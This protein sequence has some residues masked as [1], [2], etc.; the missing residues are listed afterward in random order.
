EPTTQGKEKHM[1][2]IHD[3]RWLQEELTRLDPQRPPHIDDCVA[4]YT[5]IAELG[6]GA[7]ESILASVRRA[8]PDPKNPPLVVLERIIRRRLHNHRKQNA[9][10]FPPVSTPKGFVGDDE[11]EVRD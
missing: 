6:D 3:A 11:G 8:R 4:W 7:L 10:L 2:P 5:N 9:T 1:Q